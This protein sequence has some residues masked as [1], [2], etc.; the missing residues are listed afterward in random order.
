MID[1]IYLQ[2]LTPSKPIFIMYIMYAVPKPPA[3]FKP[4]PESGFLFCA[5]AVYA[6]FIFELVLKACLTV[7]NVSLGKASKF[8]Q[9]RR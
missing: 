6:R 1:F 8:Y 3:I 4:A 9:I 7:K 5:A 2:S